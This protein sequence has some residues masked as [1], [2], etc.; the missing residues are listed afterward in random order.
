MKLEEYL[1]ENVHISKEIISEIIQAGKRKTF[2]KGELILPADNLSQKVFFIEEGLIKMFYHKDERS[3][4]HY[5]FKENE[6]ITRSENFYEYLRRE[7]KS[8]YGLTALEHGTTIFEFPF[9]VISPKSDISAEMSFLIQKIL[10]DVLRGFSNKLNSIQFEN[11]QER[12]EQLLSTQPEII[13]RAP[14]GDIA[15]YLGISQQT[16]SVIR[17]QIK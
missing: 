3:I 5:F 15:S 9:E 2:S 8:V 11:A 10:L 13:L 7:K 12:Y 16:L 4:T 6:F 1:S 14:L 17:S